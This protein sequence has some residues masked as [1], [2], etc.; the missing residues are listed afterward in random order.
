MRTGWALA[1][2]GVAR[3]R[4]MGHEK[5]HGEEI[6]SVST[7]L[8]AAAAAAAAATTLPSFAIP[9][10]RLLPLYAAYFLHG[11]VCDADA[12]DGAATAATTGTDA[13]RTARHGAVLPVRLG[14]GAGRGGVGDCAV[15][16]VAADH[17]ARRFARRTEGA[18]EDAAGGG[19]VGA[20]QCAHASHHHDG[21]YGSCS[22]Q[23]RLDWLAPQHMAPGAGAVFVLAPVLAAAGAGGVAGARVT[24]LYGVV[25]RRSAVR[26]PHVLRRLR[27]GHRLLSR[28][29]GYRRDCG[30]V[31]V[32]AY[33]RAAAALHLLGRSIGRGLSI[34]VSVACIGDVVDA[35]GGYRNGLVQIHDPLP[36]VCG[37]IALGSVVLG[38]RRN[39]NHADVCGARGGQRGERGGGVVDLAGGDVDVLQLVAAGVTAAISRAGHRGHRVSTSLPPGA[40]SSSS[41]VLADPIARRSVVFRLRSVYAFPSAERANHDRNRTNYDCVHGERPHS[42]QRVR[43]QRSTTQLDSAR[44]P[45]S[46]T[47]GRVR[48]LQPARPR[49]APRRTPSRLVLVGRGGVRV[50]R[51]DGG[52]A[53]AGSAPAVLQP[54][55]PAIKLARLC[56]TLAAGNAAPRRSST[57]APVGAGG[58]PSSSSRRKRLAP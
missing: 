55:R 50:L 2:G 48:A 51:V 43:T 30:H 29:F 39:R 37:T 40:L 1:F 44:I 27:S 13:A 22:C 34:G 9:L 10:R 26:F 14:G 28:G 24:L 25:A 7:P 57:S 53:G 11:A 42:L 38:Q 8:D 49:V 35:T 58:S 18:A 6:E 3:S 16:A 41:P 17:R 5:G 45:L 36:N 33:G 20:G 54:T 31:L 46:S 15:E 47:D 56:L 4:N 21:G 32:R 52:A 19:G 23:G 12:V